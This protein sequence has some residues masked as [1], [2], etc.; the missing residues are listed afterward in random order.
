MRTTV[1]A[2]VVGVGGFA[3]GLWGGWQLRKK[4]EVTFE[5]VTEEEQQAYAAKFE[6][7]ETSES[8]ET[9]TEEEEDDDVPQGSDDIYAVPEGTD[10]VQ[11]A[12]YIDTRKIN[13]SDKW[14][15]D[16]IKKKEGYGD[17]TPGDE[18]NLEPTEMDLNPDFAEAIQEEISGPRF[19]PISWRDFEDP[20]VDKERISVFW[21]DRD[22]VVTRLCDNGEEEVL[23]NPDI[24][25][26]F[27]LR[28]EFA[29]AEKK[30]ELEVENAGAGLV[31]CREDRNT[32]TLIQLVRYPTSWGKR[33]QQEEYGGTDILDWMHRRNGG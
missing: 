4:Q 27:D 19:V 5:V 13:Y 14:K 12:P 6:E 24:Y 25:V 26:G 9:E 8:K 18:E 22:D 31:L 7:K 2:V 23:P 28:K 10:D 15:R 11:D 16:E 20:N 17:P 32:D 21:Y 1:I 30:G 29:E 33:K 3:L